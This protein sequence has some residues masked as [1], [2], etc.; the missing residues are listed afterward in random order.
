MARPCCWRRRFSISPK[1]IKATNFTSDGGLCQAEIRNYDRHAQVWLTGVR[2][3]IRA[4]GPLGD[5]AL[6]LSP[7]HHDIFRGRRVIFTMSRN[8][9]IEWV[10]DW[11]RFNRDVHGAD[12]VLF[13]DNGSTAYDS[14]TLSA[15][16]KTIA[17]IACSVV[18]EWPYRYGPQGY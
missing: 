5:V 9:P 17:G 6:P 3:D 2:G 4:S 13:Y 8:N 7:N 18:V 11:V 16:L 14:A 10:L 12:A 1:H 15:A